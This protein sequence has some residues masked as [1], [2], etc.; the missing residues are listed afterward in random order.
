MKSKGTRIRQ[1]KS[2]LLT[3]GQLLDPSAGL[4]AGADVWIQ[5]GMI[6]K[7]GKTGRVDSAEAVDCAGKIIVPGFM[8]L[9]A[10][11]RDPG[12]EEKETLESGSNAAMYGGFTE[13]CVMPN[14]LPAVDNR[15]AVE[16]IIERSRD[17]LVAVHPVAA[18]TLDRRG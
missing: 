9:H 1:A 16:S 15:A 5:D 6:R 14:T 2:V 18:I 11:F 8:D 17:F 13:V 3:G 4:K 7:I 12:Q 10:H